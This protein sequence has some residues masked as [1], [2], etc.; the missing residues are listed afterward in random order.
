MATDY[1][2]SGYK[3][4]LMGG[5]GNQ[6]FQIARALEFKKRGISVEMVYFGAYGNLLYGLSGHTKHDD[7][8]NVELLMDSLSID[9]RSIKFQELFFIGSK[10]LLRK[11]KLRTRFDERLDL[12][13][14]GKKGRIKWDIGYFQ[15]VDHV[16]LG[17]V[18]TVAICLV[19]I[20]GL[21][22]K[23]QLNHMGFHL[24]GGDFELSSRLT[25]SNIRDALEFTKEDNLE[26][27]IA[28]NDSD[29]A[30][31][32]FNGLNVNFEVS[33]LPPKDDFVSLASAHSLFLSNSSFAFWAGL[34]AKLTHD[35]NIFCLESWPY[36]DF[37][38][39]SFIN[40]GSSD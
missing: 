12:V 6:F 36:N 31:N 24:R 23:I 38:F 5:L 18:N 21:E 27:F 26:I 7:W 3:I 14:R 34:C 2:G 16:S 29:F 15:S 8:L 40:K 22:D 20:L 35:S 4:L 9:H 39:P 33:N 1:V 17:A 30:N 25:R 37:L 32:L 11:L 19:N 10:F 13:V 28:T